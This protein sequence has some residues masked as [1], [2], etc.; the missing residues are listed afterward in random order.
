MAKKST[1]KGGN[2][3]NNGGG[4]KSATQP[5]SAEQHAADRLKAKKSQNATARARAAAN[6]AAGIVVSHDAKP[7]TSTLARIAREN[8]EKL[9]KRRAIQV[10]VALRESEGYTF[11][12]DGG[13][14]AAH[15]LPDMDLRV[16]AFKAVM[17]HFLEVQ[18]TPEKS[19]TTLAVEA[20]RRELLKPRMTAAD[21]A[22]IEAG[23]KWARWSLNGAAKIVFANTTAA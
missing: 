2:G 21:R 19:A 6:R 16:Q 7:G 5:K 17:R 22:A 11:F 23:L 4:G 3:N 1:S 14:V 12:M 9:A 10:E 15:N 13:H 20:A 18:R 8:R